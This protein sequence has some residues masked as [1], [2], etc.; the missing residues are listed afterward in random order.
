M[1]ER[2][3]KEEAPMCLQL[4]GSSCQNN[5]MVAQSGAGISCAFSLIRGPAMQQLPGES[6]EMALHVENGG[7]YL[8][9]TVGTQGPRCSHWFGQVRG[10]SIQKS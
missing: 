5:H 2:A 10:S 8:Q 3:A 7:G 1:G 6:R 9:L 4:A